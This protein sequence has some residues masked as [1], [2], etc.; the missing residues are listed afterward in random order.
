MKFPRSLIA[1]FAVMASLFTASVAVAGT[2]TNVSSGLT[3]KG[4][5]LAVHGY[6]VVAYFTDARPTRGR[7]KYSIVYKDATYRFASEA[8]LDAFED[9]PENFLPQY[10]GYCAYGVAVGAKFDGDPHLWRIVD[11][12]LYLNL[13]E[14]V[15]ATWQK[16][17]SRYI[18]KGDRN[19]PRIAGKTPEELS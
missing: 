19:W 12:K 5:G 17:I 8:H 1:A 14:E 18:K 13:N 11:G 3:A 6:D 9:D 10:G 7:A 4:P 16:R 2:E 15:Q